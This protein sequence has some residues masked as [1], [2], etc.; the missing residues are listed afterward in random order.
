MNGITT[1]QPLR[2]VDGRF[3]RGTQEVAP[4]M[5]NREQI[6]L[7]QKAEKKLREAEENGVECTFG[8]S[9]IRYTSHIRFKCGCGHGIHQYTPLC[10]AYDEDAIENTSNDW[11][12]DTITCSGCGSEYK[13]IDGR[14]KL[15]SK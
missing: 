12:G 10:E 3:M 7:L 5:G 2:L 9:N 1:Q 6:Y 15:Q 4:E 14:A 13:I 8:A 11:E